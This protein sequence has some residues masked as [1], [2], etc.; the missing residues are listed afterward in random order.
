MQNYKA[1][2]KKKKK[3]KICLQPKV[4]S[5]KVHEPTWIINDK[6]ITTGKLNY[7]N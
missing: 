3:K 5:L 2:K 7:K 6:I 4:T 1:S